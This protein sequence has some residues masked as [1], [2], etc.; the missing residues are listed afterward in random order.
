MAWWQLLTLQQISL[1]QQS[2]SG[3]NVHL[4]GPL[5]LPTRAQKEKARC[6]ID[7]NLPILKID[8]STM[9]SFVDTERAGRP[10]ALGEFQEDPNMFRGE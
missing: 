9:T 3:H 5:L 2:S 7:Q 4:P 8:S 10:A 1:K 6:L